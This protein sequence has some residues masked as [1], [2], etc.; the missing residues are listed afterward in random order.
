MTARRS[1]ESSHL[2]ALCNRH[3]C[4]PAWGNDLGMDAMDEARRAANRIFYAVVNRLHTCQH[5]W[6]ACD[7]SNGVCACGWW[8]FLLRPFIDE[9]LSLGGLA[10]CYSDGARNHRSIAAEFTALA[11][12]CMCCGNSGVLACSS[13]R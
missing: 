8:V 9:N 11:R 13:S 10:F 12:P 5:I 1:Y 6:I 4:R 2:R 3:L 7:R